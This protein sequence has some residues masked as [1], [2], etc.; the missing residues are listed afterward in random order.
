MRAFPLL[1]CGLFLLLFEGMRAMAV[2]LCGCGCSCG[3]GCGCGCIF[4]LPNVPS[5]QPKHQPVRRALN[6][7]RLPPIAFDASSIYV[8]TPCH[9]WCQ[10]QVWWCLLCVL[11]L[12][13]TVPVVRA[14]CLSA[15]TRQSACNS[16]LLVAPIWLA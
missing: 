1:L 10:K 13:A 6:Y 2:A 14:A 8:Y 3:G 12:C 5:H 16:A 15:V 7:A 4:L 11:C 9:T